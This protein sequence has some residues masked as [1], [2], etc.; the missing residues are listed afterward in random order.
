MNKKESKVCSKCRLLKPIDKFYKSKT[1]KDGFMSQCI[2]CIRKSHKVYYD[3][4]NKKNFNYQKTRYKRYK[5]NHAKRDRKTQLRGHLRRK[6]S[7]TLEDYNSMVEEQNGLCAICGRTNSKKGVFER[8]AVDHN[9]ISGQIR[10]LLCN[11]CNVILGLGDED[12]N[13]F[14]NIIS[15]IIERD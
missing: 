15:Y 9:H 6:Y 2:C 10:G 5:E 12:I 13:T 3:K 11:R 1:S 7:I 8:L 4:C 14:K